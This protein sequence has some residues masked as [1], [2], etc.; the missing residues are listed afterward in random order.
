MNFTLTRRIS[1]S[2][3]FKTSVATPFSVLCSPKY[4]PPINS[5]TIIKS[6]PFKRETRLIEI[7]LCF[8][9]TAIIL[10]VAENIDE[11]SNLD[12]IQKIDYEKVNQIKLDKRKESLA[13]LYGAVE[14]SYGNE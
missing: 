3:Y 2:L 8:I 13:F 5:L 14:R 7:P 6:I 9:I 11:F 12:N 10:V 4:I 1:S